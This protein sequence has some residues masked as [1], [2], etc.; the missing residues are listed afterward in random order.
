MK[1]FRIVSQK[2]GEKSEQ[3]L[4]IKNFLKN[5]DHYESINNNNK[6][7]LRNNLEKILYICTVNFNQLRYLYT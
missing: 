3:I 1:K 6:P 4:K 2:C 7:T 5:A